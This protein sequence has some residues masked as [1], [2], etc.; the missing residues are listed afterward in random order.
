M[1]PQ[2][3]PVYAPIDPAAYAEPPGPQY[4]QHPLPRRPRV[5]WP[6]PVFLLGAAALIVVWLGRPYWRPTDS[7]RIHRDLT[8]MRN[9]LNR[10]TPDVDRAMTLGRKVLDLGS[11]FPQY[12]GEVNFL[13]GCA[14]VHKASSDSD[15]DADWKEARKYFEQAEKAGVAE[16][17]Q[18]KLALRL[19]KAM[20][21]TGAEP[22]LV[23][24]KLQK[25]DDPES[26]AERW[27][28]QA[29]V[30]M[31]QPEPNLA[32]AIAATKAQIPLIG[33]N[34]TKIRAQA[35][36][37]LADLHLRQNE[38]Q[39]ALQALQ[40]IR[41]SDSPEVF[42]SSRVLVA[43]CEQANHRYAQ[44]AQAWE[45][46][47]SKAKP[48]ID[49]SVIAYELGYCYWKAGKAD[50]ARKAW[51]DAQ[52]SGGEAAQATRMRLAEMQL[53]DQAS[54][55]RAATYLDEALR[56]VQK[57]ADYR[58]TLYPADQARQLV[59]KA[60]Q[61]FRAAGDFAAA[62]KMAD[63]LVRL[64]GPG[65]GRELAAETAAAW[66]MSLKAEAK[67]LS[68][69]ASEHAE[70]EA[71]KQLRQAAEFAVQAATP[72][73]PPAEQS[74]WLRKAANFY[75][76]C[77]DKADFQSA[78]AILDR[79]IQ[80]GGSAPPD[81][82]VLYLKALAY[83]SLNERDKAIEGYKACIQPGNPRQA[84]ARYQMAQLMFAEPAATKAE[85]QAKLDQISEEL[86]KN[87]D[88]GVKESDP[89]AAQLSAYLLG[90][91]SYSKR[92]WLK[93]ETYLTRALR[94][95]P[96]SEESF[97]ARF[98]LGRC[99]WFQAGKEQT[100][101]GNPDLPEPERAAAIK[102]KTDWLKKSAAVFEPLE[103]DLL[104]LERDQRL[105]EENRKQ[106]V[107]TGFAAA[108]CYFFME[109][110]NEAIRRYNVLRVRYAGQIHELIALSQLWQCYHEYTSDLDK[111]K[112]TVAT[113]RDLLKSLPADAFT[114]TD[115]ISKRE[116]WENWLNAVDPP[117]KAPDIKAP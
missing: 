38:L 34:D 25:A 12:V 36:Y 62:G 71:N 24:E 117:V 107:Q 88:S 112:S 61:D 98:M 41:A 63:F 47:R 8:E 57:P 85:Q 14:Y 76:K 103:G 40:E 53:A 51:E 99:Y 83:E 54:R 104:K 11:Q 30:F 13:M 106:L 32:E 31:K 33:P 16:P 111:A 114:G 55:P 81:G 79:L 93:A 10:S 69:Q 74:E 1:A 82:E 72:D 59:E 17:D 42:D 84:R 26:P 97:N 110:F 102:R 100:A 60:C 44:A 58:N 94:D 56:D 18:P 90:H 105:T 48:P 78:V 4:Y 67:K 96:D 6:W 37:R 35:Y 87:L 7:D 15:S 116:F 91:I 27:G 65:R 50:D 80:S 89:D 20:F 95:F 45:Q 115:K 77:S 113:M 68:G 21:L 70:E 3:A 28:L 19:A 39:P 46:L 86:A 52:G 49:K 109:D 22:K 5:V 92:D 108:E 75:L 101:L 2:S 43:R 29:E 9:L 66:G 73:R 64:S 23:L